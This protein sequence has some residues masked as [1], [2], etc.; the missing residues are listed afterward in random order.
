[1][2]HL[3]VSVWP[4]RAYP[5]YA[6]VSSDKQWERKLSWRFFIRD[7]YIIK[8]WPGGQRK[9]PEIGPFYFFRTGHESLNNAEIYVAIK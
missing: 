9:S 2:R 7:I 4:R 5:Q 6:G 1:M 3:V 8:M